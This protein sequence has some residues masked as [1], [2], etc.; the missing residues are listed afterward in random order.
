[1]TWFGGQSIGLEETAMMG[2]LGSCP[3]DGRG[4]VR[5]I[6]T[7]RVVILVVYLIGCGIYEM[8]N[9]GNLD[10]RTG[11]QISL[12]NEPSPHSTSS[13]SLLAESRGF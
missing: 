4:E 11:L 5:V 9:N 10:T 2:A 6:F 8:G 7:S 12:N 13:H 3:E 1:M